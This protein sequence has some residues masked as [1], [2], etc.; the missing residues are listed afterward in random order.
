MA[1]SRKRRTANRAER[2]LGVQGLNSG[3]IAAAMDFFQN[4]AAR[5]GWGSPNLE[6]STQYPLVRFTFNYWDLVSMFEGSWLTRRI[7]EMP[8]QDALRAW[9]K[10]TSDIEPKDLSRIDRAL[11]KT[12]SKAKVLTAYTWARLLDRKSVV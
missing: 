6:N 8:A 7:V 3:N 1:S 9:P 12:N 10:L 5:T 4:V 2:A 11:R